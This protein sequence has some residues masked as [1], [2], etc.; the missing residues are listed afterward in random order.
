MTAKPITKVD[1]EEIAPGRSRVSY[2]YEG[3]DEDHPK[4]P[5]IME[6]VNLSAFRKL[7]ELED[8]GFTCEMPDANR[9]RAL[10]GKITRIDFLMLPDGWHVKKY[11]YGWTAKTK[12]IEDKT[13]PESAIMKAVQWCREEN[14]KVCQWPGGYRAW[15]G[16]EKPVRDAEAIRSMRKR[17]EDQLA[18]GDLSSGPMKFYDFAFY[19]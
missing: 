4:Q 18:R 2:W 8:Q 19:Y 6:T 17:V 10:R 13:L 12:P 5:D 3:W 1:I 15:K 16:P 11:P 14:W 9:G 7:M